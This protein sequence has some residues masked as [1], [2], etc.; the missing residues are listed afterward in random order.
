M[1]ILSKFYHCPEKN[2]NVYN[3]NCGANYRGTNG[4]MEILGV[5]QIFTRLVARYNI[6]YENYLGD[7]DSKAF[8]KVSKDLSY[9]YDFLVNKREC[10]TC[11]HK[12]ITMCLTK[13]PKGGIKKVHLVR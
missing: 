12:R 6:R 1:A 11:I 3:S 9:G 2:K 8:K 4:R 7:G 10:I 5:W 13:K